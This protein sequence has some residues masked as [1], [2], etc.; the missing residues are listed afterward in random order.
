MKKIIVIISIVVLLSS[1]TDSTEI[2]NI[3]I[4][5]LIGIDINDNNEVTLTTEIIDLSGDITSSKVLSTSDKN[6]E[7]AMQSI[8][9]LA[10]KP[11]Y[12]S[13]CNI[14]ILGGNLENYKPILEYFAFDKDIRLSSRIL[15]ADAVLARELIESNSGDGV[16]G[17][18]LNDRI[19]AAILSSK[20]VD[21]EFYKNITDM[22]EDKQ[23]VVSSINNKGEFSVAALGYKNIKVMNE[24][25]VRAYLRFK[26]MLGEIIL[27]T[28]DV[29]F[30]ATKNRTYKKI[31]KIDDKIYLDIIIHQKLIQI[32]PG[33]IDIK[34]INESVSREINMLTEF[35]DI[36]DIQGLIDDYK[37][38][39]RLDYDKLFI[40][41]TVKNTLQNT[42]QISRLDGGK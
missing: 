11:V 40:D 35:G 17:F 33:E 41:I 19:N 25:Q 14:I 18:E 10:G 21:M 26:G 37:L 3:S 22:K 23:T 2:E 12:L 13:H 38:G 42:G 7:L 27:E 34:K 30:K 6:I 1:C 24:R 32:M 8:N 4:A 9:A 31:K 5:S 20:T 29:N 16:Y 39:T 28:D 15:F 36:L